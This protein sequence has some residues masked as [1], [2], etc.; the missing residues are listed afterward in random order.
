MTTTPATT[1]SRDLPRLTVIIVAYNGAADL[2]RCLPSVLAANKT[3]HQ[4]RV[5]VVD[6][7]STDSSA[8]V[9]A[10]N[11]GVEIIQLS[12]NRGFTG[13]NN[14]A[15]Q[16]S[17]DRGDDYAVLLNQDTVVEPSWLD[18]LVSVAESNPDAGAVQSLLTLYPNTDTVNSWGNE[19]HYLGFGFAGGNGRPITE[20]PKSVCEISYPS[21]AAVL[22]RSSCL[23]KVGLLNADLYMYHEDL[24]LGWMMRLAGWRVLLAPASVVHHAYMFSK[25][26]QKFYLMERNRWLVLLGYWRWG[27]VLALL[28][29]LLVMEIGQLIFSAK[30]GFFRRRLGLYAELFSPA[31][32]QTIGRMR[33]SVRRLRTIGDRAVLRRTVGTIKYQEVMSPLLAL[34]NPVMAAYRWV[35]L[36]VVWW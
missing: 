24:A 13:G 26:I 14:V 34:A 25:S 21:G 7:A 28:P 36:L 31:S 35:I 18:E 33:E 23:R 4:R 3:N 17:I 22:L 2:A 15:L 32:W 12:E 11:T 16:S 27:T 29:M 9:A 30:N 20:V 1:P 19:Q 8:S 6:N 5:V 10:G